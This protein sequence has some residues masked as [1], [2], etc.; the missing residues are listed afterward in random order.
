MAA[1]LAAT[2]AILLVLAL[3]LTDE[4]GFA[5]AAGLVGL[6]WWRLRAAPA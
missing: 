5:L 2:A 4:A 1:G 3:P 6:H